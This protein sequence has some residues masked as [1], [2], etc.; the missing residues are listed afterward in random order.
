V[1]LT[2]ALVIQGSGENERRKER[3][4]QRATRGKLEGRIDSFTKITTVMFEIPFRMFELPF[5]TMAVFMDA[6]L[7]DGDARLNN[8]D[9]KPRHRAR[10]RELGL[11][12][13]FLWQG[14]IR[15]NAALPV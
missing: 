11:R 6:I 15:T 7:S 3:G 12:N 4:S 9:R 10:K 2:F 8:T 14:S 1:G 5:M 13:E